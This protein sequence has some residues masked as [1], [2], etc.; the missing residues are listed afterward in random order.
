VTNAAREARVRRAVLRS[1]VTKH[2]WSDDAVHSGSLACSTGD[3]RVKLIE[4]TRAGDSAA[5]RFQKEL[6]KTSSLAKLTPAA[7]RGLLAALTEVRR[8][9]T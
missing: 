8:P 6:V 5:K 2:A 4:R 3:R 9:R 7:R 1:L